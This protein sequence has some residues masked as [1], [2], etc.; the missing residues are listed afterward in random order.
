MDDVISAMCSYSDSSSVTG[1]QI[2]IQL[3]N[4]MKIHKLFINSTTRQQSH[5][6]VTVQMEENGTCHIAIFPV[7][8]KSGIVDT[9]IAYSEVLSARYTRKY[10]VLCQGWIQNFGRGD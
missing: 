6:P 9:T 8:G 10:N 7:M 2:I 5:R 4:V 1:F 3:N